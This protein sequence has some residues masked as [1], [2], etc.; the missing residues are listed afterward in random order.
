MTHIQGVYTPST[1]LNWAF[2]YTK[3]KLYSMHH[4]I[5]IIIVYIQKVT[6]L[7][8]RLLLRA[9]LWE[10]EISEEITFFLYDKPITWSKK[11]LKEES[12]HYY[13]VDSMPLRWVYINSLRY[14]K[15]HNSGFPL[16]ISVIQ[17]S[18]FVF[19]LVVSL[20]DSYKACKLLKLRPVN[21]VDT[22]TEYF[23]RCTYHA[24]VQYN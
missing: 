3:P 14:T 15:Q 22:T 4:M 19:T 16:W 18:A 5:K 2:N 12:L 20:P 10:H 7:M 23:L 21:L 1:W 11:V 6:I 13:L 9:Q 24:S 8:H 17:L